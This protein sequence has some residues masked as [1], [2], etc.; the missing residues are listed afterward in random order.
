MFPRL[1]LRRSISGASRIVGPDD[2]PDNFLINDLESD[3]IRRLVDKIR[4]AYRKAPFGG[5]EESLIVGAFSFGLLDPVSN[6][7]VNTLL[8]G[9]GN[10]PPP[11]APPPP[12]ADAPPP[13]VDQ[14]VWRSLL[15]MVAFLTHLFPYLPDEEAVVYLDAANAD[16]VA[17][18]RL[19]V[20]HRG[21]AQFDPCSATAVVAA[22]NALRCAAAAARHPY[23]DPFMLGWKTLSPSLHRLVFKNPTFNKIMASLLS[24]RAGAEAVTLV[25]DHS[26]RL[27]DYRL[28]K[29]PMLKQL[30]APVRPA[31]KR[32]LLQTIY[33]FYLEALGRLPTHELQNNYHHSLLMGGYCYGPLDPVSNIIVN[34]IWY[35]QKFPL[36]AQ[37]FALQMIS[38]ASLWRI[39]A[40]SMYGLI[41][42]LCTR[43]HGLS[44]DEAMVR[45]LSAEANLQSVDSTCHFSSSSANTKQ[46]YFAAATAA[47]H[48]DPSLHQEFVGSDSMIA[49]LQTISEILQQDRSVALSS[50]DIVHLSGILSWD[51]SV[52]NLDKHEEE[53]DPIGYNA[54]S[55]CC[56][57]FWGQHQRVCSKVEAALDEYNKDK[58]SKY[59]V[60]VIC[61]VNELVSGPQFSTDREVRSYN[62]SSPHKYH[63]S[64]VNFLAKCEDS[65]ES[66][67]FFAE[68]GNHNTESWCIPVG[69]LRPKAEHVRCMYCEREG[70]RIV[71]PAVRGFAGRDIEFEKVHY[72]MKLFDGSELGVYNNNKIIKHKMDDADWVRPVRDDH[73]YLTADADIPACGND[74]P[75]IS[76]S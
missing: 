45:L 68:C 52:S 11:D 41:S 56:G 39:V 50:A 59:N 32:M 53:L 38:A 1:R 51:I 76:F 19:I 29:L 73:I 31:M 4:K 13:D 30:R 2:L 17:A 34:T 74:R 27:A 18:A 10:L 3:E 75:F 48:P 49:K 15:G 24:I 40:Q 36:P 26:W 8:S 21:M 67:L 14:V 16:P 6:I 55:I 64:H 37:R 60:H 63:H 44:P 58:V 69:P 12:P 35:K 66:V 7:F 57:A 9:F 61:G 43:Y 22:E 23:P 46:A 28:P 72:G 33:G 25:L 71:H 62:P 20:R 47:F 65:E 5:G 70:T 54:I 42:F